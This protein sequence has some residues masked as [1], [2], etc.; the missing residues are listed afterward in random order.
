M[1]ENGFAA[2]INVMEFGCCPNGLFFW[3]VPSKGVVF[4]NGLLDV[5]DTDVRNLSLAISVLANGVGSTLLVVC[6]AGFCMNGF[7]F[8]D[9][10]MNGLGVEDEWVFVPEVDPPNI[11]C[12][13]PIVPVAAVAVVVLVS[14]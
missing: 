2:C 8:S 10:P 3:G 7:G 9:C 6:C 4:A 11:G 13:I 14:S 12:P 5:S 1:G